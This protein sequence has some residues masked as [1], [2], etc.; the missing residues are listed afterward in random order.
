MLRLQRSGSPRLVKL[1]SSQRCAQ[2]R[3][4]AFA[5]VL[6]YQ[7]LGYPTAVRFAKDAVTVT[8]DGENTHAPVARTLNLPD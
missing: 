6:G 1:S 3:N 7:A 4:L 8:Y 5:L 2:A